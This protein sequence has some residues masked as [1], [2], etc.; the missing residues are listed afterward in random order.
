MA[1]RGDSA[2]RSSTHALK[3]RSRKRGCPQSQEPGAGFPLTLESAAA[4][5]PTRSW[6]TIS[7]IRTFATERIGRRLGRVSE[8]ELAAVVEGLNEIVGS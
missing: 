6:I 1:C 4:G 5:L 8:E 3:R 2:L 7:Q